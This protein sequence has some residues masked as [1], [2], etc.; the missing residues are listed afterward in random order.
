MTV[1]SP[2][3]F[4]I[5]S[6]FIAVFGCDWRIREN[7]RFGSLMVLLK[8]RSKDRFRRVNYVQKIETKTCSSVVCV[9][10]VSWMDCDRFPLP[11]HH[12]SATVFSGNSNRAFCTSRTASAGG[13]SIDPTHPAR[14]VSP[15]GAVD[16]GKTLRL[17]DSELVVR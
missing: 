6:D 4:L 17:L 13:P 9:C 1:P 12:H 7:G 16:V 3:V 14:P 2:R 5:S 15:E 10:S 11:F 8:E